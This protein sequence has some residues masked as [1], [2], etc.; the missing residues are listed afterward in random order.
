MDHNDAVNSY[1]AESYLLG[2]LDETEAEAFETHMFE[3]PACAE[4]VKLGMELLDEA[5]K[6]LN[7]SERRMNSATAFTRRRFCRHPRRRKPR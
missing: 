2:E 3:C 4:Q 5:Y 6:M 1:A 7:N